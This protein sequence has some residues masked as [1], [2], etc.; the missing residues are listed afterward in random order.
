M[1]IVESSRCRRQQSSGPVGRLKSLRRLNRWPKDYCGI[2]GWR[3][4]RTKQTGR[5]RW[6]TGSA[7]LQRRLSQLFR[8]R[9]NCLTGTRAT[10]NPIQ[11]GS[12]VLLMVSGTILWIRSFFSW[13]SDYE[14]KLTGIGTFRFIFETDATWIT[15]FLMQIQVT[16]VSQ[17]QTCTRHLPVDF[18]EIRAFWYLNIEVTIEKCSPYCVW[19]KSL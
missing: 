11:E 3:N 13:N 6:A 8:S 2:L 15:E 12:C 18:F 4:A 17:Q 10:K 14:W 19:I 16:G 1:R 5:K 7:N 9:L